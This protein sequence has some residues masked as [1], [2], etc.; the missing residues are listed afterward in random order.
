M[1]LWAGN[2]IRTTKGALSSIDISCKFK[3]CSTSSAMCLSSEVA[4][5]CISQLL[6][7]I[8]KIVFFDAFLPIYNIIFLSTVFANLIF[9]ARLEFKHGSTL[10]AGKLKV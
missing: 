3:I 6:Q 8:V 9:A 10:G 4:R 7:G 5:F 1:F 2:N